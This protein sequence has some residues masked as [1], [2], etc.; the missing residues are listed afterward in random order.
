[1]SINRCTICHDAAAENDCPAAPAG[2]GSLDDAQQSVLGAGALRMATIAVVFG[3]LASTL[4]AQ[5]D[6]DTKTKGDMLF[7]LKVKPLLKQK[8]FACHG[9]GETTEGDLILTGRQEMLLGGESSDKVL[10]PGN[11]KGS[12]L[13][14]ST[15]RRIADYQMPPKE[16]DRLTEEQ[17]WLLRDWI[18]AG[19]PWPSEQD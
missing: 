14:T 1:M 2:T 15:T 16:A 18:D 10:I 3:I 9:G 11:A 7:A 19:A 8:C 4:S 6:A 12:L 17:T 5:D 13:Y